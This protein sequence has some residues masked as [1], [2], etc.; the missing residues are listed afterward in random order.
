MSMAAEAAIREPT[1]PQDI[2]PGVSVKLVATNLD[3]AEG[4]S[5]LRWDEE[6]AA[7]R[8]D[9]GGTEHRRIVIENSFS[10]SFKL[11]LVQAYRLGGFALSDASAQSDV[12]NVW[13]VVNEL[14]RS[15]TLILVR[16]N[17]T[18]LLP[19]WQA[20]DG[21]EF[22]AGSGTTATWTAPKEGPHAVLLVVSDGV[23]R[24]G[25][26]TVV[27]VNKGVQTSPTPL[28]TFAPP[29]PI[30]TPS[31]EPTP[32][33]VATPTP[34]P[35]LPVE[36][37]VRVDGDDSG[38]T[39]TNDETTSP[40]S[41][42]TYFVI[43]DNDSSTKVNVTS[44]IDDKVPDGG[45]INTCKTAGGAPTVVGIELDPDD[46]DGSGDVD[47]DGLDAVSCTYEVQAP[48]S[49]GIEVK[50]VVTATVQSADGQTGTDFDDNTRFI[51]NP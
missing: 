50:N 17:E 51:T 33:A 1:N 41:I 40:G 25:R 28:I 4:A 6:A 34:K 7:V 48:S 43:I 24:F 29:T 23:G 31:P 39:A 10:V 20:P 37:G 42:V 49:A 27:V 8:F 13:P 45:I 38:A 47:P 30:P 46:G 22:G 9:I 2:K 21:G 26:K 5:S 35:T 12:S 18:A 15:A 44:L 14:M 16:P 11:E 36:M 32:T 3:Q 19:V